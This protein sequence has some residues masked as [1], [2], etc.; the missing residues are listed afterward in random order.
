VNFGNQDEVCV[1]L[2]QLPVEFRHSLQA[3]FRVKK[4]KLM[5]EKKKIVVWQGIKNQLQAAT[6]KIS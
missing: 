5:I 3:W 2:Q 6:K 4:Y 1:A